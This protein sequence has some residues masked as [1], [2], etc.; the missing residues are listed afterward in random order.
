MPRI[1][2]VCKKYDIKGSEKSF[3]SFPKN[4]DRQQLWFKV[5]NIK[6][7]SPSYKIRQDHFSPENYPP[8]GYLKNNAVPFLTSTRRTGMQKCIYHQTLF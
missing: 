4:K 3:H 1:C 8:S 5:C 2:V 6:W 7:Y